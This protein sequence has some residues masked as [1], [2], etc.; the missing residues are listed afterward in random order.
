MDASE[1]PP[2]LDWQYSF[3]SG[4]T[5]ALLLVD[6]GA[7]AGKALNDGALSHIRQA[8]LFF[9]KE[10][11][12]LIL[13]FVYDRMG[14]GME[15]EPSELLQIVCHMEQ[16]S[17]LLME[18][19]DMVFCVQGL[20]VGSWGE[21][22]DSR[23]LT[24]KALGTLWQHLYRLSP[25]SCFFAVRRPAQWKMVTGLSGNEPES[26]LRRLRLG[27]FNDGLLG[28]ATDLGTFPKEER[29]EAIRFQNK[30]CRFVPNGGEAVGEDACG[31][32]ERAAAYFR[33]IHVS[34]LNSVYDEKV[35]KRWKNSTYGGENGFSFIGKHLGYRFVLTDV[36]LLKQEMH[37]KLQIELEN[38]GFSSIYEECDILLCC[39]GTMVQADM[40]EERQ[41]DLRTL[42][43][44]ERMKLSFFL[45]DDWCGE[46]A[47]RIERRKDRRRIRLANVGAGEEF[48][49]GSLSNAREE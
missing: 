27:L 2:L 21:M 1:E 8:F 48:I 39:A 32:V 6:I 42:L 31:D 23:F 18:F 3:G 33:S 9:Q 16:L 14:R 26:E 37:Q 46:V 20:F 5:L 13:R 41:A 49:I 22:H 29:E 10:K 7:F 43:P 40:Q 28:S 35:L 4:E 12:E 47:V 45:G 17:P 24:G 44:G 34:Y 38:R 30:I 25:E 15:K 36:R 19:S 11:K